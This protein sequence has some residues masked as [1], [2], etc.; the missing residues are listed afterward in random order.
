[1]W[2]SV[3]AG[4]LIAAFAI[5][6][7]LAIGCAT[8]FGPAICAIDRK[9]QA[10]TPTVQSPARHDLYMR[11]GAPEPYRDK[12]NPMEKTIGN[13][14]EG[15]RLYDLR[16]AVCHGLMGVGD[17]QGGASLAVQPADLGRSLGQ[18]LYKD[19]FFYW[20]I[21]EGGAPFGTDMPPFKN[22]LTDRDVWRILTF[23]RASFAEQ[24]GPVADDAA[25]PP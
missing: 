5:A 19:D 10:F 22:D 2:K 25:A 7:F 17:G 3:L 8:F 15:A 24:G 4:I 13:I 16:C 14:V 6:A 11:E 23:M 20:S 18:P 9:K 12:Q 1:M 21:S